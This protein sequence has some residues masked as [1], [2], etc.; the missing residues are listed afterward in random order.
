MRTS[1]GPIIA[2]HAFLG[3]LL[4]SN[5]KNEALRKRLQRGLGPTDTIYGMRSKRSGGENAVLAAALVLASLAGAGAA[6]AQGSLHALRFYGT[7]GPGEQD[8]VIFLLD[9]NDPGAGGNTPLDVGAGGFTVEWWMRGEL[10]D[11]D[12]TN[13]GGDVELGSIDWIFGNIILDRDVWCGSERKFGASIAGG[14]VRFGVGP[15]DSGG[16]GVTLEGDAGVLDGSW[17]HVALVRDDGT[18]TLRI[19]VDGRLDFESSPASAT[20][21]VSYPDAGVPIDPTCNNGQLLP[22]GW[23]LTLAAEKHD[24]KWPSFAGFVDELRVWA[25]A[26]SGAEILADRAIIVP[27]TAPGLAAYYRLEEGSGTAISDSSAAGA[28]I[29]DLRAGQAGNGEWVAYATDPDNTAPIEAANELIF[30]DGFES[31]DSSAWSLGIP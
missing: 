15:G 3:A 13:A 12:T 25:V 9:D 2:C 18:E 5:P 21:D 24:L 17:H 30:A 1:R 26:R 20:A 4:T 7:G 19:Y 22:D 6:S 28:P 29:G 14:F 23:W 10:A 27:P 31:G 16:F 8:R 11:N